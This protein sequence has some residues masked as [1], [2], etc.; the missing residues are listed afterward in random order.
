MSTQDVL[1]HQTDRA[2]APNALKN[3]HFLHF[4]LVFFNSSSENE[5]SLSILHTISCRFNK[6]SFPCP[7]IRSQVTRLVMQGQQ[8]PSK[9]PCSHLSHSHCSAGLARPALLV[10]LPPL[11][12]SR[13]HRFARLAHSARLVLLAPLGSSRSHHSARLARITWLVSLT[14]LGLSHLHCSARLAL[15]APLVSLSLLSSSPS[16]H[17]AHLAHTTWCECNKQ[18]SASATSRAL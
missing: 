3:D 7:L 16:Y 5:A 11:C 12:M 13:S 14:L 18:S 8:M 4:L 6:I 1:G 9:W 2:G 15:T 10:L 17:S